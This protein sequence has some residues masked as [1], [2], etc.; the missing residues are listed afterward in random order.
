VVVVPGADGVLVRPQPLLA[1]QESVEVQ[2]MSKHDS[3]A[4]PARLR[5]LRRKAGVSL[6]RLA[7]LSGV[8]RSYLG[9]LACPVL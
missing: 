1:Q 6:Y 3:A 7:Q 9:H 4:F 2:T 8:S 5:A